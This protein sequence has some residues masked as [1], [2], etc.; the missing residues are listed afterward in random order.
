MC[1]RGFRPL[2]FIF[3]L[4]SGEYNMTRYDTNSKL[5]GKIQTGKGDEEL[6]ESWQYIFIEFIFGGTRPESV[7]QE[8]DGS[9]D[10]EKAKA[11]RYG[12]AFDRNRNLGLKRAWYNKWEEKFVEKLVE[13]SAECEFIEVYAFTTSTF[14]KSLSKDISSDLFLLTAS[15]FSVGVYTV[16]VLGGCSAVHLRTTTAGM[17]FLI[18]VLS[19][20]SCQAIAFAAGYQSTNMNSLLPFLLLGIGVDDMFVVCNAID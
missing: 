2:N 12:Y 5:L 7:K 20:M 18:I 19:Y 14:V 10:I 9:N 6:Y 15:F 8:S 3:E 1:D 13:F 16:I 17:G 11:T 4:E